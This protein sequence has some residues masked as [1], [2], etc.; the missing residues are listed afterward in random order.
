MTRILVAWL[1]V[2]IGASA[3]ADEQR[4]RTTATVEVLD[5]KAP[6]EDVISRMRAEHAGTTA[7]KHE[8]PPA[9][10][11]RTERSAGPDSK[12]QLPGTRRASRERDGNP[13]QTERPRPRRR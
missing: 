9:P 11:P 4:V 1:F 12:R 8:R 5:D 10:P 7:L 2:A 3:H 13:E 6:I